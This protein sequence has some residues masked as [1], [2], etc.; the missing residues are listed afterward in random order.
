MSEDMDDPDIRA[1][2]LTHE[3]AG[4]IFELAQMVSKGQGRHLDDGELIRLMGQIQGL[5]DYMRLHRPAHAA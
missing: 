1:G 3:M 2:K 5:I 4:V